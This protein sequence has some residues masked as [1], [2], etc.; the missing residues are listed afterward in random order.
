MTGTV[1]YNLPVPVHLEVSYI[2]LWSFSRS[3]LRFCYRNV[4]RLTSTS[5]V[6]FYETGYST[7]V[8]E[9]YSGSR[10]LLVE[11]SIKCPDKVKDQE[12]VKVSWMCFFPFSSCP[13]ETSAKY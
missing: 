7:S 1:T 8:R 2:V 4:W 6:R 12:K 11:S 9:W 5:D 3:L 13:E 10:F